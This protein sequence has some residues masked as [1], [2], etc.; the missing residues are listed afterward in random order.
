VSGWP[1]PSTAGSGW[2][3]TSASSTSTS[4]G[5][6]VNDTYGHDAGDRVLIEARA[7]LAGAAMYDAKRVSQLR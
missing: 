2:A 3:A 5:K 7:R 4:T 1:R 6:A